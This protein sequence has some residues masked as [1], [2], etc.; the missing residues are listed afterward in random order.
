[1][2]KL[3][4]T[5]AGSQF[6]I[7]L[8]SNPDLQKW[9]LKFAKLHHPFHPSQTST[10]RKG[11]SAMHFVSSAVAGENTPNATELRKDASSAV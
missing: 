2:Y 3:S 7:T 4:F 8:N 10:E 6:I 11:A 1:M 5:E 9:S